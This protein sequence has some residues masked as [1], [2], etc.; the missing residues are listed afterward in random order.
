MV[1]GEFYTPISLNDFIAKYY[2]PIIK[3]QIWLIWH[4]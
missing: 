1:H 3:S 2:D 4:V